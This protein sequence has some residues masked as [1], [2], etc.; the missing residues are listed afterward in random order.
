[1]RASPGSR[2]QKRGCGAG[3][4]WLRRDRLAFIAATHCFVWVTWANAQTDEIQVYNAQI[5]EPGV[6]NMTLHNN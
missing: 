4:S 6:F 1:M 5:A 3:M 2:H